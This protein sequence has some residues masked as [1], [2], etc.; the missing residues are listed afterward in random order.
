MFRLEPYQ[1]LKI[2]TVGTYSPGNLFVVYDMSKHV[3]PTAPS[4]TTT[5][6]IAFTAPTVC[7]CAAIALYDIDLPQFKCK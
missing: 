4:P 6:L 3:F 2:N 5:H 1:I 7:P